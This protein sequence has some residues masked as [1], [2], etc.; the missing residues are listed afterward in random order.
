MTDRITARA[1]DG[2]V[3][4]PSGEPSFAL[5]QKL[6]PTLLY[7]RCDPAELPFTLCSE[8]AEV[9]GPL[10]Q[11]RAIEAIGLALRMRR[12]GYNIYAL[13]ASG[14]GRHALVEH[15]LRQQAESQPTPPDWCYV[16]NFAD[17]SQPRRLR[18]SAGRGAG[19][20]GSFAPPRHDG[21][22]L[23]IKVEIAA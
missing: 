1:A 5:G 23:L 10:G 19:R 18:L 3:A 11:E 14:T 8:L 20:L 13:G 9:P 16:N 4:A 6:P 12:K 21:A 7:R 15:L 22:G 2:E 17:P